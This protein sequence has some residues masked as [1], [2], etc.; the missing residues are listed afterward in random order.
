MDELEDMLHDH[1]V[2]YWANG[3]RICGSCKGLVNAEKFYYV[4][5]MCER[6]VSKN[7]YPFGEGFYVG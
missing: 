1:L 4:C 6:Q 3:N 7:N 2:W 5:I